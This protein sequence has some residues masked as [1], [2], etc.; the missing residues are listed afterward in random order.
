MKQRGLSM[1]EV[2][3]VAEFAAY[4]K[5]SFAGLTEAVAEINNRTVKVVF[6]EKKNYIKVVTVI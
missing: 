2:E 3:Y 1:T 6:K 4:K 5:K